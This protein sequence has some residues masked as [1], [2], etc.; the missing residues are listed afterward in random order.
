MARQTGGAVDEGRRR[1]MRHVVGR[2]ADEGTR[3]T[4]AADICTL[5]T[6]GKRAQTDNHGGVLSL[7]GV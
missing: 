6:D 2:K 4:G 5:T 7:K 3:R 1:G